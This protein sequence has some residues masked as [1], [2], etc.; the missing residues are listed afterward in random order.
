MRISVVIPTLNA[1]SNISK[2]LDAL[3][4]GIRKPNEVFVCDGL[5]EDN[6]I[7][8]AKK[9]PVTVLEN[10]KIHAAGGRNI[11]IDAATGEIIAFTDSDCVPTANWIDQIY[12]EFCNEDGLDGLGGRVLPLPPQNDVEKFAG[13]VFLNEIVRYPNEKQ[14]MTRLSLAGALITNNCAYKRDILVR[15]GAFR[16]ECENYAE[17]IDL[18]WRMLKQKANLMYS[19]NA[20]VYHA[21]PKTRWQLA[22]KYYQYGMSSSLLVRL[23]LGSPKADWFIHRKFW[24]NVIYTFFSRREHQY[25]SLYCI[26]LGS[27]VI[28]KIAGSIRFRVINI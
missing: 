21:Y 10:P 7:S 25:A 19:P 27:H 12:Q 9:F 5:S 16:D 15:V 28:G 3:F 13:H 6:T 14:K 2:T 1:G 18:Y 17:D 8:E 26:Q 4:N 20:I 24:S 23:H 22:K 11:G